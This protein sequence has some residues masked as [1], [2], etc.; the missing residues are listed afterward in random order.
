[1]K[2]HQLNYP[3]HPGLRN[4]AAGTFSPA[5]SLWVKRQAPVRKAGQP[6]CLLFYRTWCGQCI[7]RGNDVQVTKI[8]Y[9][10]FFFKD[11]RAVRLHLL[12]IQLGF[13]MPGYSISEWRIS[14]LNKFKD[15]II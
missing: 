13:Q 1:L 14:E 2:P 7:Y 5:I 12:N 8:E 11:L 10:Q 4:Q 15:L 9:Q 3:V 6:G